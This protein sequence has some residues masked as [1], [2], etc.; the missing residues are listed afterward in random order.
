MRYGA[1]GP[2]L[3]V[4]AVMISL[5]VAGLAAACGD[6]GTSD[7]RG[8]TK[9]P[10]ERPGI[11]VRGERASPM[12]E[13]GSPTYARADEI[14]MPDLATPAAEAPA[15]PTTLPAGVTQVDFDAGQ[16]L[17][18]GGGNC[19]S[20]HGMDASGGALGPNLRDG[21]WLH[22]DGSIDGIAGTIQSGV[23]QPIQYPVGMPAMGGAQLTPEQVRQIAAYLYTLGQQ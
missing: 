12:R 13:L 1:N 6:P 16:Q 10:L 2:R 23:A 21:D 14:D 20:C 5:A 19:F 3:R 8:Y 18:A 7:G 17:Y 9:A 15:P 22:S 11:F 4:A